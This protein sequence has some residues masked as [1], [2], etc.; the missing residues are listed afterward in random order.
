[1]AAMRSVGRISPPM[2][3]RHFPSFKL[4]G[5]GCKGRSSRASLFAWRL[6]RGWP[7]Y[8]D[9]LPSLEL[10]TLTEEHE[11]NWLPLI[12]KDC[13]VSGGGGFQ[14]VLERRI[15]IEKDTNRLASWLQ[16]LRRDRIPKTLYRLACARP[17]KTPGGT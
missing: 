13:E 2:L 17:H 5:S 12:P 10:F 6:A 14:Q 7:T 1:M 11:P 9:V 16:T 4:V 3:Q 15:F 8:L